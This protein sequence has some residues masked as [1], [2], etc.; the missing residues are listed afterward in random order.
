MTNW[1]A[2]GIGFVVL[3]VI[4]IFS[5][6]IPVIGQ[7]G[8]GLIGGFVAGYLAGGDLRRGAWHGLL[9]GSITGV[10]LTAIIAVVGSLIVAGPGMNPFGGFLGGTGL[11]AI[12]VALTL[13]FA[14]DSA[15]GGAV[16]SFVSDRRAVRRT[17]A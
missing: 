5:P 6:L 15:I 17:T 1:R 16:G 14:L 3:L 12:G 13:L 9:A 11:F 8:A 4:G 7:I 10:V 2:V